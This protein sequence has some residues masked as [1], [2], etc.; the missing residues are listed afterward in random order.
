MASGTSRLEGILTQA[1]SLLHPLTTSDPDNRVVVLLI[2]DEQ[3]GHLTTATR[4]NSCQIDRDMSLHIFSSGRR[5]QDL[6][7]QTNNK[8][9]MTELLFRIS[10]HLL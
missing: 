10:Q 3:G 6:M 9:E 7:K 8:L 1:V 5:T 2:A 4:A